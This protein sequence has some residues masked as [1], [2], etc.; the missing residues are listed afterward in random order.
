MAAAARGAAPAESAPARRKTRVL[1]ADEAGIM[2]DGLCAL[3]QSD[4]A[5]EVGAATATQREAVQT[6]PT[7]QPDV[8]IID[9][10]ADLKSCP[11]TLGHLQRPGPAAPGHD[12]PL[13]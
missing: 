9:F 12:L 1:V 3:L 10:A 4:N 7:A 6:L 13:G 11:E 8:I 2:R 5:L